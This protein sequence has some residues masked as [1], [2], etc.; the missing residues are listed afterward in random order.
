MTRGSSGINCHLVH[1]LSPS[2]KLKKVIPKKIC[3]I[4]SY[5]RNQKPPKNSLCFR[6]QKPLKPSYISENVTFSTQAQKRK[7]THLE[8][9][10]LY[11]RKKTPALFSL[12]S[13]NK[14]NPPRE[15][16]LYLRKRKPRENFLY[17]F[18]RKLFLYFRKRK[19]R[20]MLY[21]SGNGDFLYF[22]K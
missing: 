12:S 8:N 20:K 11:F 6:K 9:V 19:P 13:R 10:F 5:F 21:I 22:R 3:Y 17:F 7:K 4:L 15:I 14:K 18:K 2:P 16:F 1:F